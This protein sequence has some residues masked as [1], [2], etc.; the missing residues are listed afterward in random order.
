MNTVSGFECEV[1]SSGPSLGPQPATRNPKPF[2]LYIHIP[3][4]LSRCHYCDFNSYH[5][6]TVQVEQYLEA[7]AQEIVL[8]ASSDAIRGRRVC[9]VFFGGGTPSVL[10]ASQLIGVLDQCRAAF[11]FEAGAEV[12]LEA[13]PGT[14]DLPKLRALREGGVTR[15]S[16]GVQA[17]Q[18]RLL[19]RIGRA[20][21]AHEAERAFRLMREA[22]FSNI[23]LDLM[24]GLPGQNMDDWSETLDWAI[25]VGPE[26][27]SAYGL[28]LEEGTPL[29]QEHR[30]G[31]IGLP[32]EETET[33]MYQM[34]VDRLR[35]AG[36]E[37]Y[38]ISNFARP[39]FRCRHNL[40]YWQ[41][42]EYHGIG[43]GAHSFVAGRRFYN[44]L[45]P[46]RYVSA[47]AERGTA[48]A[49]GEEL[50][51]EML[52]SERLML[53]LRLRSGLDVQ[54]FKDVLGV[55]ELAASDRVTRL[56]DDGFL[57]LK[58]GRVQ[59]AERGLLVANELIVQLL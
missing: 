27:L 24:F 10:H 12:S 32:D 51:A 59:I 11:T 14:V 26:H 38:E 55:E 21:T 29:Y 58:D 42:Q 6:D 17:I 36:F 56:L 40:V 37:H 13:N 30:K 53:G 31:E 23:N 43:A 15:L 7:L 25:G 50:S 54:T 20:H 18:D 52:R 16:V 45:L 1:A 34:A 3:Y 22:G 48:V 33:G 44:E 49:C 19:Q 9:S 46:A 39:G 41:H 57:C 8:R 35:N 2:G 47:I 28:I 5:F 4:C